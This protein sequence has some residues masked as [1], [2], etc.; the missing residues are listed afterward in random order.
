MCTSSARL[1]NARIDKQSPNAIVTQWQ[2]KNKRNL[3]LSSISL[4]PPHSIWYDFEGAFVSGKSKP[5]TILLYAHNNTTYIHTYSSSLLIYFSTWKS[6]TMVNFF[7]RISSRNA[8]V[9]ARKHETNWNW[10]PTM[11]GYTH[12][13]T[14][15]LCWV[16]FIRSLIP[17]YGQ[18]NK[19]RRNNNSSS[20]TSSE[21]KGK[22]SKSDAMHFTSISDR[23]M[24]Y[25]ACFF[26]NLL[27]SEWEKAYTTARWQQE[28]QWSVEN[29][30]HRYLP[31]TYH[32]SCARNRIVL[33][34]MTI[35]EWMNLLSIPCFPSSFVN[36]SHSTHISFFLKRLSLFHEAQKKS[37]IANTNRLDT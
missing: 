10:G 20:S 19:K 6:T 5:S 11:A 12:S 1:A 13:F 26:L 14:K 28:Q 21:G 25:S 34:V 35:M 2:W 36:A 7:N 24:N 16:F 27:Q 23:L 9:R 32:Y 18:L 3:N 22:D 31:A 8:L 29:P 33:Y 4:A 15:L 30:P 17:Y 37:N